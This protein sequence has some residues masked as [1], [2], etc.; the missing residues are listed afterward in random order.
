[1][2][3]GE[4]NACQ[5]KYVLKSLQE[6]ISRDLSVI[7]LNITVLLVSLTQTITTMYGNKIL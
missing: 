3:D 4:E 1:M 6:F 5:H 2:D 7:L